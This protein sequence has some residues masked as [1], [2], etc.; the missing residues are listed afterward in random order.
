LALDPA[1]GVCGKNGQ[2]AP[3]GVHLPTLKLAGLLVNGTAPQR[4]RVLHD[5]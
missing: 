1:I 3:V 2:R 5:D 4:G